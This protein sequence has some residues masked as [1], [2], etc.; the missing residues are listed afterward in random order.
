MA[1]KQLAG[2]TRG[3]HKKTSAKSSTKYIIT[4]P[5]PGPSSEGMSIAKAP[6]AQRAG[7]SPAENS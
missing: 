3:E 1:E 5:K 4:S 7:R 6:F 2:K